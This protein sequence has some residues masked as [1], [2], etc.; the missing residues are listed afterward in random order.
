MRTDDRRHYG[1]LM[2]TLVLGLESPR[3]RNFLL[4]ASSSSLLFFDP[5]SFFF[6]F[7]PRP[8]QEGVEDQ[9]DT[10]NEAPFNSFNSTELHRFV[11]SLLGKTSDFQQSSHERSRL[12]RGGWPTCLWQIGKGNCGVCDIDALPST[13]SRHSRPGRATLKLLAV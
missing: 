8:D 7:S 3:N 1:R 10:S 2:R 5:F 11:P 12:T 13:A 9:G 4:F 6:L